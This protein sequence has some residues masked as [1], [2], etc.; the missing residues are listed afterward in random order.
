MFGLPVATKLVRLTSDRLEDFVENTT[1]RPPRD[2][3]GEVF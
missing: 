3:V 2:G 1:V